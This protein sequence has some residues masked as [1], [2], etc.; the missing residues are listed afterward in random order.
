MDARITPF[1]EAAWL[2][3]FEP[4][5]SVEVNDRVL[6]LAAAVEAMALPGVRDV[7]PASASLVVHF[8]PDGV[9]SAEVARALEAC[10]AHAAPPRSGRRVEIPVCYDPAFGPDL[11]EIAAFANLPASEVVERHAARAYRV[12]MLGF[13][14]G[15]PY[16]GVV[17]ER[18][19]APRLA[20]PRG[21]VPA[22]SVG[23]AG[24]QTG[25]Y[26]SDSPG[27]WQIIGRTPIM[28]FDEGKRPPAVLQPGDEVRFVP[29]DRERFEQLRAG[30]LR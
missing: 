30:T 6:G 13:L 4:R 5:L 9:E 22:G 15:F 12:F 1:G 16:L 23:I 10:L 18:I 25:I 8:D 24:R 2:V 19:A 11:S 26:P 28:L 21:R 3:R 7:V 17:D 29:I 14:P 20:T 27:G